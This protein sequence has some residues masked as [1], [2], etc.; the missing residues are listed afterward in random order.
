MRYAEVYRE[1]LQHILC[2]SL[3]VYLNVR[4]MSKLVLEF[5]LIASPMQKF[6]L[7]FPSTTNMRKL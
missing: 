4:F 1:S 3:N 5:I 2:A 6:S 7:N